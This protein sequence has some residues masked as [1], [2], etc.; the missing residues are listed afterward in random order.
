MISET[1]GWAIGNF[2]S[3]GVLYHYEQGVWRELE[4]PYPSNLRDIEMLSADEGWIVG[5]I[6]LHY[7]DGAWSEVP[8]PVKRLNGIDMLSA[9]EGWAVGDGGAIVRYTQGRW[10]EVASPTD[11][12]LA[13]IS[14]IS[15]DEGW[16]VGGGY[17]TSARACCCTTRMASGG[18]SIA[19]WQNR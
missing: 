6:I 14:M 4:P 2:V 5:N 7:R 9:D 3:L 18:W 19:R 16:A 8:S 11:E 12:D 15:A 10:A 17:R 13:D 1:E